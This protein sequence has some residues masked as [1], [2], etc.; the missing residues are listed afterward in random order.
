MKLVPTKT[1]FQMP[2]F[3]A[4]FLLCLSTAVFAEKFTIYEAETQLREG[5]YYLQAGVD[6]QL[7]D[8]V[9]EALMNGVPV[10]IVMRVEI[11]KL[12][13]WLWNKKV[14]SRV[15][16]FSLK[17]RSLAR[18]YQLVDLE[19]NKTTHF[20]KLSSALTHLGKVENLMVAKVD[21]LV[22]KELYKVRFRTELNVAALPLPLMTSAYFSKD[23]NLSSEWRVW[24]L[25][26]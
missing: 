20:K 6:Y 8:R 12:R 24:R 4:L 3:F 15:V 26:I 17:Y 13:G 21:D 2:V 18:H 7:S 11:H 23:W 22:R 25:D 9:S 1:I 5:V 19:T 10:E 14:V 16:R